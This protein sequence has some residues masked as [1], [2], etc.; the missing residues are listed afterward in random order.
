MQKDPELL[1]PKAP[2]AGIAPAASPL[3][4]SLLTC[5]GS[6]KVHGN[7]G[8]TPQLICFPL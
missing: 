8:E 7:E 4:L 2:S 3:L 1:L 5:A 6:E